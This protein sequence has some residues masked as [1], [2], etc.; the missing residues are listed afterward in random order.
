M[1]NSDSKALHEL[2]AGIFVGWK[3]F[4]F[5]F[6]D[7]TRNPLGDFFHLRLFHSA[8]GNS[9]SSKTNSRRIIRRISIEWYAVFV[10][11]N[12]GDLKR[13]CGNSSVDALVS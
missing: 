3:S 7:C 5:N 9:R 1:A 2:A 10:G 12:A 11:D 6:V 8:S 13:D 4:I